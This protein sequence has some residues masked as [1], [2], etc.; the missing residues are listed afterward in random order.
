MSD[1]KCAYCECKVNE[2]SKDLH[3]EHFYQKRKYPEKVVD[4]DNLLPACGRCNRNKGILDVQKSPILNPRVDDPKQSLKLKGAFI[5]SDQEVGK[6]TISQLKLNQANRV[7][8][9]R[10]EVAN[11]VHESVAGLRDYIEELP[12]KLN[13]N[14]QYKIQRR[15]KRILLECQR[16]K[17]YAGTLASVLLHSKNFLPLKST[18]QNLNLWT[19]EYAQL[20]SEARKIAL[21]EHSPN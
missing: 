7:L 19:D 2:E 21:P 1:Q 16:D 10:T 5:V 13:I 3:I 12:D 17:P 6:N 9:P 20:E 15:M 4:W 14:Q 11:R 8:F 18:L